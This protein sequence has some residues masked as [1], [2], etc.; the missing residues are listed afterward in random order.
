MAFKSGTL[1]KID[2]QPFDQHGE[3]EMTVRLSI[4]SIFLGLALASYAALPGA[5]HATPIAAGNGTVQFSPN[6]LPSVNGTVDGINLGMLG[7][8]TQTFN[9]GAD[10][11]TIS[12]GGSTASGNAAIVQG[13][14]TGLYA[15]PVT[16]G[17]VANPTLLTTPYLSTELGTITLSF[18]EAQSYL[19]FLW[20]SV[21]SGDLITFQNN[22]NV[23]TSLSGTEL[24]TDAGVNTTNGS[25]GFG[26]SQYVLIDTTLPFNTVVLSQSIANSFEA[27][28]FEYSAQQQ[29]V[30]VPE[31]ASM[32]LLGAGLF[33]MGL[34]RRKKNAA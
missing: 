33:G 12:F 7:S 4:P 29:S 1:V 6:G 14:S 31:P 27:G 8:S 9:T 5:A 15:A 11:V 25:Q 13:S 23:V 2:P 18:N 20:G 30:P 32:A 26:G 22:G 10:S 17:T 19:G 16:G 28:L 21:G 3:T 34:I 24:T